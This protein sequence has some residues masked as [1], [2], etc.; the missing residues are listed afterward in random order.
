MLAVKDVGAGR[1]E[2][3]VQTKPGRQ[4]CNSPGP[5]N[6]HSSP[7]MILSPFSSSKSNKALRCRAVLGRI[8][9]SGVMSYR[10]K[11]RGV[12]AVPIFWRSEPTASVRGGPHCC[13]WNRG[14][15]DAE[16]V[17]CR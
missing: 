10:G 14:L 3:P 17:L 9:C 1:Q 7:A 5:S 2:A 6:S 15:E 4:S 8:T 12:R 13:G 11:S 16:Q